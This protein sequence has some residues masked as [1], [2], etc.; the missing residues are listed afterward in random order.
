[1]TGTF[2]VAVP[3]PPTVLN[4]VCFDHETGEYILA[5]FSNTV[6]LS[7]ALLRSNRRVPTTFSTI[8]TFPNPGALTGRLSSVVTTIHDAVTSPTG[9]WGTNGVK[10][11]DETGI[12]VVVGLASNGALPAR[13]GV[14]TRTGTILTQLG[15][16]SN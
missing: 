2:L 13:V 14:L 7:G 5:M 12:L 3:P 1:M 11:D 6:G 16:T 4:N 8:A 15:A 9:S 10:C